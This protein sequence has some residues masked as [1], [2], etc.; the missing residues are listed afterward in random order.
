MKKI[1]FLLLI[2]VTFSG[3]YVGYYGHRHINGGYHGGSY[4]TPIHPRYY[5]G[6]FRQSY[7]RF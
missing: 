4:R 3:C 5:G 2:I 7:K 6:Q 1:I